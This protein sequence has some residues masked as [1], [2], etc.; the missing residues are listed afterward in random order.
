[1]MIFNQKITCN[2][3]RADRW[4]TEIILNYKSINQLLSMKYLGVN[5]TDMTLQEQIKNR[6]T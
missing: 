1:M 5:I 3:Q 6:K 2:T 4:Q